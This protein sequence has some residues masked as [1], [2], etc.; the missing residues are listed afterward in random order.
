MDIES[1]IQE[2]DGEI[3]RKAMTHD[4]VI[5]FVMYVTVGVKL[6]HIATHPVDNTQLLRVPLPLPRSHTSGTV[7]LQL[8]CGS[9]RRSDII[10]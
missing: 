3:H 6:Q 1:H 4:S 5:I 7:L 9:P 10:K 2:V 8:T